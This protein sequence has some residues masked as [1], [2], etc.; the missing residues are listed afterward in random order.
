MLLIRLPPALSDSKVQKT[1]VCSF[2]ASTESGLSTN[3]PEG[4]GAQSIQ[5]PNARDAAGMTMNTI[6]GTIRA[7]IIRVRRITG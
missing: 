2:F 4:D 3:G 1:A 7:L 5:Y 6:T